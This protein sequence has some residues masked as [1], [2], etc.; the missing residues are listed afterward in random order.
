M[1]TPQNDFQIYRPINDTWQAVSSLGGDI[2][3]GMSKHSFRAINFDWSVLQTQGLSKYLRS[4]RNCRKFPCRRFSLHADDSQK[5]FGDKLITLCNEL[6]QLPK[7]TETYRNELGI[8]KT[9][10][11]DFGWA[12][13]M[14][15]R[16]ICKKVKSSQIEA[17]RVYS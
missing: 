7:L 1:E 10:I 15:S 11:Y 3:R 13:T 12:I 17:E 9:M 2:G 16:S 4:G 14:S 8:S 5:Y 6:T